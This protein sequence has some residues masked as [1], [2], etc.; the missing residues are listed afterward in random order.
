M[1]IHAVQSSTNQYPVQA[2]PKSAPS[3]ADIQWALALEAKVKDFDYKPSVSETQRYTDIANRL[4]NQVMAQETEFVSVD[5]AK[6]NTAKT[7]KAASTE[8]SDSL[9]LGQS[10]KTAAKVAV[11][12]L[13]GFGAGSLMGMASVTGAANAASYVKGLAL[14][15][16]L[17][18]AVGAGVSLA[19]K[20][21]DHKIYAGL[22]AGTVVGIGI[23]IVSKN[24]AAAIT[25]GLIGGAAGGFG[26]MGAQHV[27]KMMK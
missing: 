5:S 24:P 10:L 2:N 27:Q 15:G 20:N 3:Q 13:T 21:E 12:V 8:N 18:G 7:E 6:T 17:P 25:L 11:P 16:G 4:S 9:N 14:V 23:A 26:A 22:G 1:T 19:V